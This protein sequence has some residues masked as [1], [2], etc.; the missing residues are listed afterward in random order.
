VARFEDLMA[1]LEKRRADHHKKLVS[2]AAEL[3]DEFD[4]PEEVVEK[5]I[6]YLNEK[7]YNI[8]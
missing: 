8:A 2:E 4:D 3:L 1:A 5:V 7:G 6:A